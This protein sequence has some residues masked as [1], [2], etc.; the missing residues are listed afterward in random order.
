[1]EQP[2]IST[3]ILVSCPHCNEFILI[4]K[5]NC[6]IFRHGTFKETG[7]QINPHESKELCDFYVNEGM[8]YGCGRPFKIIWKHTNNTNLEFYTVVC[9]YI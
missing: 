3:D 6:T 4:E 7:K 2:E 8:I 9:D 5:L 1:M